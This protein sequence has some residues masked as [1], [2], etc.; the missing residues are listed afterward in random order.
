MINKQE[1]HALTPQA[2][3]GKV[4]YQQS[5]SVCHGVNRLGGEFAP[6]VTGDDFLWRYDYQCSG[7]TSRYSLRSISLYGNPLIFPTNEES[8][9]QYI[10]LP[11]KI[12]KAYRKGNINDEV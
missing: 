10:D 3:K 2:Q 1:T 12:L 9:K 6:A 4:I 7:R 8:P 11:L 5:C